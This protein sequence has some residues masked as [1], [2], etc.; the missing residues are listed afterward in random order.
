MRDG[1]ISEGLFILFLTRCSV[2]KERW[3]VPAEHQAGLLSW[4]AVSV[5]EGFGAPDPDSS[6][7][8]GA[9]VQ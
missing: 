2:G 7:L 1:L 9:L 3:C 4:S 5:W 6:S 8:L